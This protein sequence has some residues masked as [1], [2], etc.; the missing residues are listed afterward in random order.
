[1]PKSPEFEQRYLISGVQAHAR[2][3]ERLLESME[4]YV[5]EN[6]G[7]LILLPMIGSSAQADY[8]RTVCDVAGRELT[9]NIA[10]ERALAIGQS[11][12]GE[13]TF[14]Y[15]DDNKADI[16][17]DRLNELVDQNAFTPD[18]AHE[19]MLAWYELKGMR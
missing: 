16:L 11:V 17:R 5:A 19:I 1:M 7:R 14:N 2:P 12:L 8:D 6:A 9:P 3:H 18:E 15:D 13:L 4:T 10:R